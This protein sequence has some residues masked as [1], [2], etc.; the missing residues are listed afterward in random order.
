[1]NVTN[2]LK[3]EAYCGK[4]TKDMTN[5]KIGYTY[6]KIITDEFFIKA[7][8]IAATRYVRPKF[9]NNIYYNL[10]Y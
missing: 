2:I 1:M 9:T 5:R 3:N 7:R 4:S 8:E 6:P 10:G